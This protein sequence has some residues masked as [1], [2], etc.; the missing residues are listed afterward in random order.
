MNRKGVIATF[1]CGASILGVCALMLA[2]KRMDPALGDGKTVAPVSPVSGGTSKE[3]NTRPGPTGWK[4][5]TPPNDREAKGMVLLG[6]VQA[7][8]QTT[9][10]ARL[11]ALIRQVL[12]REGDLVRRGQLLVELD[13]RD[14]Y[15]QQSTAQAGVD[16]AEAQVRKAMA[17]REAQRIKSDSDVL[18]AQSAGKQALIKR[19]QTEIA[20]DA[21][22]SET[23]ADL[24]AARDAEKKAQVA[25]DRASH[26]LHSLEGL[27]AVGGVSRND[28][29]DAR[30]QLKS[31]EADLDAAHVQV[32][33]LQS[34][35]DRQEGAGYR[36]AVAQ[37]D[38]ELAITG[39]Q[40]A[41]DAVRTAQD[42]RKQTLALADQDIRAADAALTQS[43]SG[44]ANARTASSDTHL[45]SPIDGQITA[46]AAHAGENAQPGA[47]LLTVIGMS[48]LLVEALVSA[49]QLSA[50]H[51]GQT[52]RIQTDVAANLSLSAVLSQISHVAEADG[53]SFRVKFHLLAF[54]SFRPGQNV[55][56]LI[57]LPQ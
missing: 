20:V 23:Q 9:L 2:S 52:A 42:A 8:S 27:A 24:A 31:A 33:R 43:R 29:E 46:V 48:D 3:G 7:G 15:I 57:P 53:R 39:L 13:G 30:T 49:R 6:V 10:S 44:I 56:I 51:I 47:P 17:A 26:L 50:L 28:L 32:K 12:A 22:R 41:R 55:R 36:V 34:S 21:A 14:A 18:A 5:K 1:I 11:P 40:Q 54:S 16:A 4:Q 25:V 35:P 19:R 38:L 45:K 37:Q